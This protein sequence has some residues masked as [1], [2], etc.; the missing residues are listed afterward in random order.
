MVSAMLKR[1]APEVP[2]SL[3]AWL[4]QVLQQ[5]LSFDI[6]ARPSVASL[7]QVDSGHRYCHQPMTD[8][9]SDW[10]L[11]SDMWFMVMHRYVVGELWVL[12]HCS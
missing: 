12:R 11:F 1:R 10:L 8:D 9:L 5:C 3:P 7:H 2:A 4:Q 6:P